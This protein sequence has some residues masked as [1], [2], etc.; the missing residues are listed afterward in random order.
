V[1]REGYLGGGQGKRPRTGPRL[2]LAGVGHG[3]SVAQPGSPSAGLS[4]RVTPATW[5]SSRWE[6]SGRLGWAGS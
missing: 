6:R 2:P 1:S 4:Q 3:L 5:L